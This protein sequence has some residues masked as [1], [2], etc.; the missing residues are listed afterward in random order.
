MVQ[1][2]STRPRHYPF[3]FPGFNSK[4]CLGA[5]HPASL[6]VGCE[7][8]VLENL[9]KMPM[10]RQMLSALKVGYKESERVMERVKDEKRLSLSEEYREFRIRHIVCIY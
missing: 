7:Q 8:N 6:K 9:E 4:F 1:A 3:T 10:V 2:Y 5:G